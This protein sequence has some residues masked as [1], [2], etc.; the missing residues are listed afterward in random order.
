MKDLIKTS[1][2]KLYLTIK[3][4]K[5]DEEDGFTKE[6]D[7]GSFRLWFK[8]DFEKMAKPP[9]EIKRSQ[10]MEKKIEVKEKEEDR[11]ISTKEVL[12]PK[13]TTIKEEKMRS[14]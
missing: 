12:I 2:E 10:I 13:K 5:I 4:R 1:L 8:D 7:G 3:R 6:Q 14:I 9:K 11:M